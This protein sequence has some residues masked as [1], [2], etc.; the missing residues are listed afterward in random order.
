MSRLRAVLWDFGGVILAS[1]FEAFNHYERDH[2]L[3]VDFIR[4]VNATNPHDNAWAHLERSQISAAQFADEFAAESEALGHRVDGNAVLG[5]LAGEVRPEMVAALDVVKAAGYKTACLTNN[6]VSY[7][8]APPRPDVAD[9]LARFDALIE[10][11]KVGVRKPEPRFYEIACE[12]L[13]VHPDECVFLDD[14]G[15]N[16]KTARQMG[17]TTIKVVSSDQARAEL[18]ALLDMEL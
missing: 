11:A 16:L 10:S 1:P 13:D 4:T 5:L 3:P 12:V 2:G 6:I 8:D 18:G 17:M 14:L 7:D 15:I 9:A